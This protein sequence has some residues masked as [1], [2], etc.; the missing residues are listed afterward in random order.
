MGRS[1]GWVVECSLFPLLSF[2]SSKR[3]SLFCLY[4]LVP[5]QY[6]AHYDGKT[7]WLTV[8]L[9]VLRPESS[10]SLFELCGFICVCVCVCVCER[11]R[12]GECE[13]QY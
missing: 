5:A 2:L 4:S 12:V 7:D 1:S 11:E 13:S 6:V 8:R 10:L 9:A 3:M